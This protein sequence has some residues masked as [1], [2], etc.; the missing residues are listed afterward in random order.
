MQA[1]KQG[2]LHMHAWLIPPTALLNFTHQTT[3][4][5]VQI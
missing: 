1:S 2:E 3:T 5:A 4:Y